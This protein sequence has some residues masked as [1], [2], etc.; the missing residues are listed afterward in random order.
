P[1][2]SLRRSGRDE[3]ESAEGKEVFLLRLEKTLSFAI[4]DLDRFLNE[5]VLRLERHWPATLR[6]RSGQASDPSTALRPSESRERRKER[7]KCGLGRARQG[8]VL[9]VLDVSILCG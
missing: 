5:A 2:A 9:L 7:G 8:S 6:L 1:S 4:S 3:T